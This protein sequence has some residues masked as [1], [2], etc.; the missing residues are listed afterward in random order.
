VYVITFN[1]EGAEH[2]GYYAVRAEGEHGEPV[3]I[4]VG[5]ADHDDAKRC[6]WICVPVRS[7]RH[8]P[9]HGSFHRLSS[10]SRSD[11][12]YTDTSSAPQP[13][14]SVSRGLTM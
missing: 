4:I 6:V 8:F 12:V 10:R 5:F 11:A 13:P 7:S 2:A 3:D 14:L 1:R 9:R